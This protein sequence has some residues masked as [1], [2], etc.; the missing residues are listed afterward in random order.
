MK[1]LNKSLVGTIVNGLKISNYFSDKGRQFFDCICLCGRTFAARVDSIKAGTTQSCGCLRGDLVSQKNRLPDNLGPFNLV[2]RIYKKNAQKRNLDFLL[3]SEEFK[4]LIFSKCNY[5]GN[6][7]KLSKF[8]TSQK[9][10]RD[11]EIA[12]NGVDRINNDIGYTLDNCVSC[13]SICNAA[14]SDMSYEDFINWIKRLVSFNV[15]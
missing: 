13:C 8:T 9:N 10:R 11:R 7:P 2:L 15:K 4:R 5:C 1:T 3:S 14:K 12:Y 6:E